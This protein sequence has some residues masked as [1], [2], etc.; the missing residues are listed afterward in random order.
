MVIT[1]KE[2]G[3][4]F[5]PKESDNKIALMEELC[6]AQ[7][8]ISRAKMLIANAKISLNCILLLS[9]DTYFMIY[10]PKNV[11]VFLYLPLHRL[12]SNMFY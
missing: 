8:E 5:D 12:V 4:I 3:F 2:S 7:L 1:V 9:K 10:S 6:E 11:D